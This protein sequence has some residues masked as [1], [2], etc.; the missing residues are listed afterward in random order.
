MQKYNKSFFAVLNQVL[1]IYLKNM[2]QIYHADY[3]RFLKKLFYAK[4]FHGVV[5]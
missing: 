1:K 5:L 2:K 3:Q 4:S